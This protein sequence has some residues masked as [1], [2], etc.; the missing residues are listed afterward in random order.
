MIDPQRVDFSRRLSAL[1]PPVPVGE[2]REEPTFA[3]EP[4][5]A[6][7]ERE[8]ALTELE[9]E[10]VRRTEEIERL[11]ATVAEQEQ[12]AAKTAAALDE[13]ERALTRAEAATAE[14]DEELQL[15]AKA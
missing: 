7:R 2:P 6:R 11:R 13:R 12:A 1:P 10:L 9:A 5:E 3:A 8:D 15:A 14:R 4:P